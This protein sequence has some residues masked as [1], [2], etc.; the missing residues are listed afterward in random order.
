[1]QNI[2]KQTNNIQNKPNQLDLPKLIGKLKE[3]I[4]KLK[5]PDTTDYTEVLNSYPPFQERA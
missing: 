4:A 2:P 5:N 3:K 1:M